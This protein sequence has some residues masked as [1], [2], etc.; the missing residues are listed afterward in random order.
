MTT[1]MYCNTELARWPSL[2]ECHD[3]EP[4]LAFF[5]CISKMTDLHGSDVLHGSHS[6]IIE[7]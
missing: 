7:A 5:D 4:E 1:V 3:T 2:D 6:L